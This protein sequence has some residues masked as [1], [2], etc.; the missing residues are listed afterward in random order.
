[1]EKFEEA[2]KANRHVWESTKNLAKAMYLAGESAQQAKVEEL[3]K[4]L[5]DQG[6][7]FNDQS[8][9]AKDLG[10]KNGE[11]QKRVDA[12]VVEIENLYLSGVIGFGTVK[13]L[14][15]ALKGEA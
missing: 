15:Q 6:Q 10:H 2:W 14:E 7:R 3:Q 5:I 9:R 1:M 8:Q 12:V 4:R 13:K 11:L